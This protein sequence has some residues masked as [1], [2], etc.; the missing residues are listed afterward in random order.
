MSMTP[1]EELV[2]L[3]SE[4]QR[5]LRRILFSGFMGLLL[6]IAMSVTLGVYYYQVSKNLTRESRALS[7]R[8]ATLEQQAFNIRRDV[9]AQ[10]NRISDQKHAISQAYEEIRLSTST[11]ADTVSTPDALEAIRQYLHYG[12]QSLSN[13]RLIDGLARMPG[14]SP[15]IR[16]AQG[17]AELVAWDLSGRALDRDGT[18]LPEHLS[19][20]ETA[21]EGLRTDQKLAA[22]AHNG[23]AQIRFEVASSARSNYTDEDCQHVFEMVGLSRGQEGFSPQPLYWQAACER[24]T[25]RAEDALRSFALSLRV[26]QS[27]QFAAGNDSRFE[28]TL[29]MNA[30]H[31]LGTVL[32]ATAEETE[33]EALREAR[34]LA[35]SSCRST[36]GDKGSPTMILARA[37]LLDAMELR[38]RLGQTDNQISGTG[39]NLSFT[40]LWDEHFDRAFDHAQDV[41][42]TGVFAWNELV[43]AI[44]AR[45]IGRDS[46]ARDAMRNVEL[47]D[48]PTS[49]NICEIRNLLRDETYASALEIMGEAYPNFQ[50]SC[51]QEN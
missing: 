30:Y 10:A 31:G 19:R 7:E 18:A 28:L 42:R 11:S 2:A 29:R 40:Y 50:P 15:E 17:V 33:D 12:N 4:E 34:Q 23:L 3:I 6:V 9:D 21:F 41:E 36:E 14:N 26:T 44:S 16:L 45:A 49:F 22:L 1:E 37:C 35:Q 25:G 39:E 8:S 51:A 24:K 38:R 13:Q 32:I 48:D 20:A 43:R 46:E 27:G 47:F 5:G